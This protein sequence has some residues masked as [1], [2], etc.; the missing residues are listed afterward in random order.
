MDR[1]TQE[2]VW[3]SIS[4]VTVIGAEVRS[5][6]EARTPTQSLVAPIGRSVKATSKEIG[7]ANSV[8][9]AT[10]MAVVVTSPET[11]TAE[12][13][14]T[15][16]GCE[17]LES[18]RRSRATRSEVRLSMYLRLVCDEDRVHRGWSW[19]ASP[20]TE[21]TRAHRNFACGSFASP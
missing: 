4:A 14:K 21:V 1:L 15:I 16:E 9:R 11:P 10:T 2:T 6:A 7:Q 17:V 12:R 8:G 3:L 5:T 18:S 13:T 19:A 20:E